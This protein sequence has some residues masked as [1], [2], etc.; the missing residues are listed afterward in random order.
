MGVKKILLALAP[1]ISFRDPEQV[2]NEIYV[3]DCSTFG[4]FLLKDEDFEDLAVTLG[5]MII[6][7]EDLIISVAERL[8]NAMVVA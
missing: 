6:S 8:E 5:V 7:P 3:S 1:Y 4:D 2:I